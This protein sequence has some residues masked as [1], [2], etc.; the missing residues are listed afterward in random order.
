[1]RLGLRKSVL[2]VAGATAALFHLRGHPERG[3][4]IVA[5]IV[6]QR[7]SPVRQDSIFP[8]Q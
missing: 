2:G 6:L 5:R 7:T 1:M 8:E 4:S 3:L